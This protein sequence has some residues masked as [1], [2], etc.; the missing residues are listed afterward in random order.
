MSKN[1]E[2]SIK[3]FIEDVNLF[4]NSQD[5]IIKWM[6]EIYSAYMQG[7]DIRE[8]IIN[9]E[10]AYPSFYRLFL[11]IFY[12]DKNSDFVSK[13]ELSPEN[14]D[15]IFELKT[16]YVGLKDI[17]QRIRREEEGRINSWTTI[18]RNFIF[19]LERNTPQIEITVVSG[20]K[21]VFYTKDNIED[22]Y[23]LSEN[24]L[25]SVFTSL[26]MCQNKNISIDSDS[27][28]TIKKINLEIDKK[29]KKI[30]EII[31][32]KKKLKRNQETKKMNKA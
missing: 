22:I 12:F 10:N 6:D 15:K 14:L 17:L 8:K 19:D 3:L 28:N 26:E 1:K 7:Y 16:R 21:Q 18:D 11:S 30:S 2:K 20:D 5:I 31:E 25:D 32:R 4:I 29:V 13:S 9:L 27:I 24:I 23:S